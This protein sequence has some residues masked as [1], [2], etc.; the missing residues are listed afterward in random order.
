MYIE[1]ECIF[2]LNCYNVELNTGTL[3]DVRWSFSRQHLTVGSQYIL[4]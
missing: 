4:Q 2:I 3:A 1:H